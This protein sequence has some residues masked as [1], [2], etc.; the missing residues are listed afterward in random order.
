MNQ[1]IKDRLIK[2]AGF[3][4]RPSIENTVSGIDWN[5][6][7]YGYDQCVDRLIELVVKEC[8]EQIQTSTARD[9][10]DTVQYKQSVGH[11]RKIKEHFGV[12]Y[13]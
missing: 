2:E 7:S 11:Q 10:Q 4:F 1:E 12:K 9:P 13:E 3:H 5:C 6:G 8:I